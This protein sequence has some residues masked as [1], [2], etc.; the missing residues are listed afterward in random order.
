M[1]KQPHT[2]AD[3]PGRV[4]YDRPPDDFSCQ[5]LCEPDAD[6]SIHGGVVGPHGP[7]PRWGRPLDAERWRD[8]RVGQRVRF[9][10]GTVRTVAEFVG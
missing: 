1:T 9:A 6:G 3:G 2:T 8:V 5:V 7:P 4:V 10:G